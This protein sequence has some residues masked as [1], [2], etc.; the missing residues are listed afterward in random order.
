[1]VPTHFVLSP[2]PVAE[3]GRAE[4]EVDLSVDPLSAALQS[5]TAKTMISFVKRDV[6][7]MPV[8]VRVCT[9]TNAHACCGQFGHLGRA[10]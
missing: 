7:M 10:R 5:E 6:K 8:R 9:R 4:D 1:M 2:D 3:H